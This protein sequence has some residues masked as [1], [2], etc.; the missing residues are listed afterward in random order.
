[1]RPTALRRA[2]FI[3]VAVLLVG[4]CAT[5]DDVPAAAPS[6]AAEGAPR[7]AATLPPVVDLVQRVAGDRTQ[8]TGILPAG[9]DSH[10]YEPRPGDARVLSEA[11][12]FITPSE[13]LAPAVV[14][15]W[16][17]NIADGARG[18]ALNSEA[19]PEREWIYNESA[20]DIAEHGHGHDMNV[21]TWTNPP[22]A[23]AYVDVIERTLSERDPDGAATYAAN[24]EEIR[25]ELEALDK[26]TA[27]AVETI[28]EENRRLI[29]YHDSWDYFARHY[30]LEVVGSIQAADLAEPSAAEVAAIVE[31][32]RAAGVPVFF[33]SEVFPSDVLQA[34]AA[35]SGADYVG[36]LSDDRLPGE[37]GDPEHS[38]VGMMVANVRMIVESL[39]GNPSALDEVDPASA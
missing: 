14:E 9:A 24:A 25:A 28:P 1:M 36:D 31:Q 8:V 32:I 2:A 11:D 7:I 18:V 3:A 17:S 37:P 15:L 23:A 26:A 13:N 21:H 39:G 38:Y 35:E 4:A 33:G 29:V 20:A 27:E 34:V 6:A 19:I 30:G 10:T 16:Q 5:D 12:L 22:Y